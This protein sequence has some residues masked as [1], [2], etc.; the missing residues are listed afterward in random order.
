MCLLILT[1]SP[2]EKLFSEPAD[3]LDFGGIG[4]GRRQPW[5]RA[6]RRRRRRSP[7][8]TKIHDADARHRHSNKTCLKRLIVFFNE[9]A[10]S[11][12]N[13]ETLL[14]CTLPPV[15]L[16][17][18]NDTDEACDFLS[19]EGS[20]KGLVHLNLD[21]CLRLFCGIAVAGSNALSLGQAGADGLKARSLSVHCR[22]VIQHSAS[23]LPLAK[24]AQGGLK[25]VPASQNKEK[26]SATSLADSSFK[27]THRPR[28]R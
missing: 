6:S 8:Q 20:L 3:V 15:F 5:T 11:F 9:I 23:D 1:M 14:T 27:S 7:A 19:L 12:Q 17:V 10:A 2:A 22:L 13:S 28:Q 16:R 18:P 26:Y 24:S 4:C 25:R 21:L